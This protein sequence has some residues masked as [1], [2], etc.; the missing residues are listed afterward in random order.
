MNRLFKLATFLLLFVATA[1]A[2]QTRSVTCIV[3]DAAG[4][5]LPGAFVQVDG[6]RNGAATDLDGRAVLE[7]VSDASVIKVTLIGFADALF[8]V[9]D[10]NTVTIVMQTDI[11]ALD[12]VVVIG[13][14]T[15]KRKDFVGS[16]S[17][18]RLQNS[19]VAL[20]NNSNALEALKGTV[21]G[22]DIGAVSNAGGQPSMQM[23][24]QRSI[25]GSN[26]PLI[27]VDGAIYIGGL[28][29][30]NP[31]DI[32]TI[33]VLKDASSAAAFGSRSSNGVI[34][35]TTKKGTT[36]KPV[37]N[38]NASAA[39]QTWSN[40][41]K[42]LSP[43]HYI[44][45]VQDRLQSTDI[46]W[47]TPQE[48]ENY[49][50]GNITDWLDYAT[51]I[52]VKQDYQASVSGVGKRVNYYLSASWT[53]NNGIVKG[54]D[55]YR[56]SLLCKISTDITSWLNL[57][58]DGAYT[59]QDYSGVAANIG[60]AYF[61][62]PYGQPYR[63]GTTLLEKYPVTQSDGYQNPLWQADPDNRYNKEVRDS[64]RLNTALTVK[65]P[66]VEGLSFKLNFLKHNI[67]ARSENFV[68]E[69][70]Y[71]KDGSYKDDTRYAP[72][73][74]Q[75][76]LVN[77]NG[78][79][80]HEKTNGYVL[81]FILNFA[82]DFGRHSVDATLVSTRDWTTYDWDQTS[83]SNFASN[84]NTLLG[85]S[86]LQKAD[87]IELTQNGSSAANVGYLAR[88]MY[89]FDNRYSLTASYR[90]DGSSF[91]GANKKWGN[92]FSF[93]A[94][95]TPSREAFWNDDLKAVLSDLKVKASWGRNGNQ[96]LPA[97][98]TLSAVQNGNAAAQRYEFDG[99][100]ILYGIVQSGLGNPELGWE[101]TDALNVGFESSWFGGRLG[102]DVDGY[103]SQ[104]H[105]QIFSRDIPVPNGFE[106][107]SSSMGQIDNWGVEATLNGT[108]VRAGDFCWNT[109]MTFWWSR[110]KLVHLYGEDL[111]G[112]GK[113]DDDVASSRFIGY[114]L[115]AIYGY[116]QDGIVQVDDYD[117]IG[118][119]GTEPGYP[120]Y[121]DLNGD[122]RITAEDRTILG[123]T[124]PNFKLNW[125]NTLS[126]RG[127]EL[128]AMISGTFG[129]DH[130]WLRSNPNAYRVNGYGYPTGNCLDIPYWTE[131]NPS[132]V[133]PSASFTS[134]SRFIG[135]QDRT[136]VRLQDATL[137]YNFPRSLLS[138]ANIGALKVYL[139]G[140]NLVTLTNWVGDDPETGSYVLTSSMPVAKSLA[141]GMSINF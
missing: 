38:F 21:A 30:I 58:L 46:S 94:A 6:T 1:A 41:P 7:N 75:G 104:T 19:P 15:A 28:N 27:V 107:M 20:M 69:S 33:D 87:R 16:V 105:D 4:E 130:H 125:H 90:R 89:S 88:L 116:V 117:Y 45:A 52:G 97:F 83:G 35:I 126:W 63:Y 61:I 138:K 99:D 102:L 80:K 122:D 135:L 70:Y 137:T 101:S 100:D 10:R 92:F 118:I 8:P 29:E 26:A 119:Y 71:V 62:S 115:G 59:E 18:V 141:L 109:G 9:G 123:F 66:W 79:I 110:N 11:Q 134:D 139:T 132:D 55:F 65:C 24:G 49:E 17:S 44:Q 128:Y 78:S 22:L 81:D 95:W 67:D 76:L 51:R 136:F 111:D 2:A 127:L 133:Y 25:S 140:R 124:T 120:K 77:A 93:G 73:T 53:G 50:A 47:M 129:G 43:D 103:Y 113:E 121:V 131:D 12:E 14:G 84:G 13:Y 82:R 34:L 42:L 98:G 39:L 74:L 5:P 57:A 106:R 85:I 108:V 23:R 3:T 64:Y 56:T 91:F 86:G 112:D 31:A 48:R 68:Y 40:K 36:E 96:G 72:S 60:T 114:G 54:D 32:A 37:I